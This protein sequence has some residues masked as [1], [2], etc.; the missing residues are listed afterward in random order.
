MNNMKLIME[1]W[2]KKLIS[3]EEEL[4]SDEQKD[5]IDPE[6]IVI[7]V[8]KKEKKSIEPKGGLMDQ[9]KNFLD[10]DEDDIPIVKSKKMPDKKGKALDFGDHFV[11]REGSIKNDN[12]KSY[13]I[14]YN[15]G[16]YPSGMM[17]QLDE[18]NI[19]YHTER[20]KNIKFVDEQ[21]SSSE[22]S[23]EDT[24]DDSY[25]NPDYGEY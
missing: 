2:R 3:E 4:S 24:D 17:K 16:K 25:H 10:F 11:V 1:S 13:I 8:P 12:R 7:I 20:Y 6:T 18:N 23:Q 14:Y 9:Y 15:T 21:S 22:E 19:Y 5:K